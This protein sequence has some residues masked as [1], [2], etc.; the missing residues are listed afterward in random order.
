MSKLL[1]L[2]ML[3][4]AVDDWVTRPGDHELLILFPQAARAAIAA[5]LGER[6]Q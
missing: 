4:V 3:E 2:G 1:Q 5:L 6:E